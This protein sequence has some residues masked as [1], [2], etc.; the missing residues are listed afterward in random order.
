MIKV[1]KLAVA[2]L[3]CS[4]LVSA[5]TLVTVN[6]A[7]ITDQDVYTALMN[8]TQGR[9]NQVPKDRL[10]ELQQRQL[11]ELIATELIYGD[12]KKTGIL[13]SSDFKREYKEFQEKLKKNIAIKVWQKQQLNKIKISNKEL[14]AYYTANKG[15]FTRKE[16]VHARHILVPTESEANAL[17]KKLKPLKSAALRNKFIEL[18]KTNSTGPSKT[19][20]GDLGEFPKEQMVPEFSAEAFSMKVGTVSQKPVHTQFGFHLIYLEGKTP[21]SVRKFDEVKSTIEQRLKL[22]KFKSVMKAKMQ[23]LQKKADIKIVK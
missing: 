19:N 14:K 6:G 11:D 1:T 22:E 16:T 13:K 9:L 17:L 8:A 15:E 2:L 5:K 4:T 23:N 18:A 12:A 10:P 7:A 3:M 20:G 21:A